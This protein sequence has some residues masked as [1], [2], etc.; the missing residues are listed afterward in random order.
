MR[1]DNAVDRAAGDVVVQAHARLYRG[2]EIDPICTVADRRQVDLDDAQNGATARP[3]VPTRA[4]A[5]S[6]NRGALT[7][8]IM[9]S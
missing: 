7:A 4:H 3:G 5:A 2:V 9:Q 6:R 1:H 8:V